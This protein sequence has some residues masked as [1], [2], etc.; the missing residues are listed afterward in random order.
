MGDGGASASAELMKESGQSRK[1]PAIPRAS[2]LNEASLR[3]ASWNVR[4]MYETGVSAQVANEMQRYRIH[5]LGVSET[6]WTQSGEICLGTGEKILYSGREDGKHAAG[7][8]I[9]LNRTAQK[10]LRGWEPHG[11]RIIT[12]SFKTRHKS[13]NLNLI[14]IYAPTNEALDED[15]EDFYN[16]LQDV[17]NKLPKKDVN[18]VLGDANAKIGQDNTGYELVMGC[19]GLGEMNDNGE[20]LANFCASNSLVIGG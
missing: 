15:K 12:A 14:Q 17:Y 16:K 1:D 13:I 4:T 19:N 6:H 5:I 7:V 8:A 9:I 2:P 20:R 11:E 10:S 18:I 3:I